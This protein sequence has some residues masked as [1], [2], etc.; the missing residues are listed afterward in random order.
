MNH[1]QELWETED[2]TGRENRFAAGVSLK[3]NDPQKTD[4]LLKTYAPPA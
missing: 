4:M 1:R 2:K 3:I